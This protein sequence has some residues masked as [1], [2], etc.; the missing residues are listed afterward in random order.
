MTVPRFDA[1]V[2]LAGMRTG[3]NLLESSLNA[4]PGLACH[5]EAF[6]PSFVGFPNR[7]ELL[8]TTL[9]ERDRDPDAFL[10]KIRS[11]DPETLNGFRY[12]HDHDPRVLDAILDDP[13]IAKIVLTRNP[14][15]SFVSRKI[16]QST[17][18]WKLTNLARR[19]TEK[20][21][22]DPAGFEA[23]LEEQDQFLRRIERALQRTGQTAFNLDFA[24][25]RDLE[26]LNGLLLWLGVSGRLDAVP[27]NLK[28]QNPE[29]VTEKVANPDAMA[30]AVARV[31]AFA[32]HTR[33]RVEP[34][35][36]YA[37]RSYLAAPRTPLLYLPIR[38]GPEASVRAWLARLDDVEDD[39]LIT[40]MRQP[41][42]RAWQSA[43]PRHRSFSVV[44]HPLARA[45]DVFCNRILGTGP[46]TM[47]RI[48]RVLIRK[49]GVPIPK[50]G[51]DDGYDA[52][53]HRAAFTAFLG[54]VRANLDGQTS[55]PVDAHWATQSSV[56][57][58]ICGF[59]VP[60][61]VVREDD[62]RTVLP[63]LALQAG[64]TAPPDPRPVATRAPISL[65]EIYDDR[66]ETLARAA[67]ARD[68][69]AFGYQDW[70]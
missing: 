20:I 25:L 11:A 15:D 23:H 43:H 60:D 50:D 55:L 48:R 46:G 9:A 35:R 6:N 47:T 12:F 3:S 68:Y 2:I 40:N 34:A 28:R 16:A 49:H 54:F 21:D 17:G 39:A 59:V 31:D 1:F 53:A 42:L 70:G 30:A 65:A 63:A 66:I 67:Y 5:G 19:K 56:L 14:L 58:G 8:S 18:Q 61:A 7:D 64:H 44:R 45:H 32:L 52:S 13:R 24:A 22:F 41:A 36:G 27:G 33:L 26:V 10:R 69:T 51:P 57:Q 38:S 4:V 37:V 29:P 62:M